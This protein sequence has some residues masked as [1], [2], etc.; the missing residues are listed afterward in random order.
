MNFVKFL[1]ELIDD[2]VETSRIAGGVEFPNHPYIENE[3][4]KLASVLNESY[5]KCC[6]ECQGQYYIK[7]L[8]HKDQFYDKGQLTVKAKQFINSITSANSHESFIKPTKS[9]VDYQ[10]KVK[11]IDKFDFL[12]H[13]AVREIT[14]PRAW[15]Q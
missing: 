2:T 14:L 15:P 9:E 8:K 3:I 1:K 10:C 7:D 11:F 13:L 6:L 12:E 5:K 4:W